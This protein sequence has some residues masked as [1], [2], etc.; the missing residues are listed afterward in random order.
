MGIIFKQGPYRITEIEDHNYSIS[1]LIGD[2]EGGSYT[3]AVADMEKL[4]NELGVYGFEIEKWDPAI[5]KGWESVDSCWGFIGQYS[6]DEKSDQ[7]HYIVGEFLELIKA[8]N[9]DNLERGLL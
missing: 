6:S 7:H 4:V 2:Y 1:D 3:Q 5:G 8:V 9:K